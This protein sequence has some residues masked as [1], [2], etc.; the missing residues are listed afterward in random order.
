LKPAL[1]SVFERWAEPTPQLIAATDS[2]DISRALCYD[3]K[4][5][6][7]WTTSRAALLGDAAHPMIPTLGQG[8]S[9]AIEDGVVLAKYLSRADLSSTA[10]VRAALK[11]YEAE[12]TTRT[13][14]LATRARRLGSLAMTENPLVRGVRDGLLRRF[15]Q[16][17]WQRAYMKQHSYD[18][19]A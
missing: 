1:R 8:G 2:A 10:S 18:V 14:A 7:V 11:A 4:P 12:R 15:P 9:A 5:A 13:A 17:M 6:A 19:A 16:A 3:R